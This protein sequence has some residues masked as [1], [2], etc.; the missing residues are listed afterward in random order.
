MR[1]N[2]GGIRGRKAGN[3]AVKRLGMHSTS[4]TQASSEEAPQMTSDGADAQTHTQKIHTSEDL[5]GQVCS[6]VTSRNA[7][8][9]KDKAMAIRTPW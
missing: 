9:A 8:T 6:A 5:V 3:V 7:G 1:S 2:L 4:T